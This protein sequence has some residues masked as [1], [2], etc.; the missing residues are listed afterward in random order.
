M[1][2]VQDCEKVYGVVDTLEE[3]LELAEKYNAE[4][5]DANGDLVEVAPF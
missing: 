2:T 3:A 5:F 4:V 1:Y